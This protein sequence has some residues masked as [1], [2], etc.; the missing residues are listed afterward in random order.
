MFTPPIVG[1]YVIAATSGAETHAD[2]AFGSTD[3]HAQEEFVLSEHTQGHASRTA[4]ITGLDV[5]DVRFPT[6][7]TL[8]G[9]DAMNPEPDYSAAYV[10]VCTDDPNHPAGYALAFTTGRGNDVQVRAI[11]ALSELVVG[12]RVE[13]VCDDLGG[14]SR[15]LVHDPQFRWLGPE[16]GV[17]HMAAGA[18]VNAAWDLAVETGGPPLWQYMSQHVP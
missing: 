15:A 7:R 16:K 8:D 1:S 9:S 10:T 5:T 13:D 4:R 12:R 14:L 17:I 6:S 3:A 18:V 11:E 2:T